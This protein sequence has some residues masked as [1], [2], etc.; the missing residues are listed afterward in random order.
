MNLYLHF[1][2]RLHDVLLNQLRTGTALAFVLSI[3]Q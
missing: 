2:I 1:L 3:G